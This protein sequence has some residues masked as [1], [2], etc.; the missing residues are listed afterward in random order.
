MHLLINVEY[1][2]DKEKSGIIRDLVEDN[3]EYFGDKE[4]PDPTKDLI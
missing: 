4:K 2:N 1:V 3:I